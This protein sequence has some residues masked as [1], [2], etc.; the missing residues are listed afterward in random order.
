MSEPTVDVNDDQDVTD[1]QETNEV[2]FYNIFDGQRGRTDSRYLDMDERVTAEKNRA[3]VEGRE[4][5]L[6]D[7][8]ALPPGV[9]TPLVTKGQ[10]PDNSVYSNPS[11]LLTDPEQEVDP[12]FTADVPVES[13]SSGE[14]LA[15]QDM[16]SGETDGENTHGVTTGDDSNNDVVTPAPVN[17]EV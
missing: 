2:G 16:V 8:G 10:L 6:D 12:V 9:G 14:D 11:V 17:Y 4:P 1:N 5:N 3:I 7:L 13:D 15:Y